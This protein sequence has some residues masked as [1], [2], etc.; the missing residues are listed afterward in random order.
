M[1]E[2]DLEN[3]IVKGVPEIKIFGTPKGA[4]L[5]PSAVTAIIVGILSKVDTFSTTNA[6]A[7]I[8]F[9]V[10]TLNLLILFFEFGRGA[11]VAIAGLIIAA[12]FGFA[13]ASEK[14][15]FNISF[16][17]GGDGS[18][19]AT[20]SFYLL[21]GFI[22]LSL[23]LLGTFTQRYF[24]YYVISPNEMI[25]KSGMF[26]DSARFPTSR[27]VVLKEKPDIF[28]SLLLFGSG[29]LRIMTADHSSIF[30]IDNVP[31]IDKVDDKLHEM[32]GKIEVA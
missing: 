11:V 20:A 14:Y 27:M 26:G 31:R 28:E 15:G 25:I 22:L 23:I 8:F 9:G 21:F 3:D 6:L 1:T 13:W 19:S 7:Y 10:F 30:I 12:I 24:H 16:N 4:V 5:W 18:T 29:Q 2:K 32:L 17:F